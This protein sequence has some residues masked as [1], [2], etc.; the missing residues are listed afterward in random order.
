MEDFLKLLYYFVV[1]IRNM[2]ISSAKH[3]TQFSRSFKS[4]LIPPIPL[5]SAPNFTV[6]IVPSRSVR[7]E[8]DLARDTPAAVRPVYRRELLLLL[9]CWVLHMGP[10]GGTPVAG[11]AAPG[12]AEE[13]GRRRTTPAARSL[14]P[15]P[16][17]VV[18]RQRQRQATG[19]SLQTQ[20]TGS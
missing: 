1:V 11:G 2:S 3:V 8:F 6:S 10:D 18:S 17:A 15:G 14:P 12:R 16:E 19:V 13:R 20:S 7:P 4:I 5:L 9:C